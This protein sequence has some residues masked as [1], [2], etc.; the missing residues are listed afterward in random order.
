MHVLNNAKIWYLVTPSHTRPIYSQYTFV[1][2]CFMHYT[3]TG[4]WQF[5]L[6]KLLEDL[7]QVMKWFQLGLRLGVDHAKLKKIER[8]H[9]HEGIECYKAEML[10]FWR[11]NSRD[12]SLRNFVSA[13]AEIGHRNLAKQLREKY[14]SPQTGMY[15]STCSSIG[16]GRY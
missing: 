1:S 15:T 6:G 3:C 7:K 9:K 14:Y 12:V 10:A 8:N 2:C 11:D 13:L 4:S 16:I 5:D